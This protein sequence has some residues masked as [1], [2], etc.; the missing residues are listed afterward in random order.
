LKSKDKT[1]ILA[2]VL[3]FSIALSSTDFQ[4]INAQ[5]IKKTYAFVGATP[6]PIGVNQEVLIHLGITDPLTAAYGWEG[7]TVTIKRPDGV[8]ETL[9]PF[10]TDATGGTGTVYVPTMTGNYSLQVHFPEQASK[11]SARGIPSGTIYASSNSSLLTLVVT[12]EPRV[13]WPAIPLPT[14]YWSRPINS[15]LREWN[16]IAGSFLSYTTGP[17]V[18]PHSSIA[19]H[20]TG[21]ETGHILWTK[22]ITTGGLAGAEVR[23]KGFDAAGGGTGMWTPPII[24]AG[25]LYYN[26]YRSSGGTALEQEVV[27]VDIHTGEELWTKNLLDNRRIGFG[28]LLFFTAP[29]QHGVFA[30]IWIVNGTSWHAFDAYTG[31]WIYTMDNVPSG[32]NVYGPNGEILRYTV[33]LGTQAAQTTGWITLWNTTKVVGVTSAG[34]WNPYARSINATAGIEWN[35]TIPKGL[36]GAV[37]KIRDGVIIGSNYERGTIAPD[38][39]V[40][41]G[42]ST[43]PG[44][45]GQLLFNRTWDRPLEWVYMNIEDVS[46]DDDVFTVAVSETGQHYGFSTTT[47]ERIW[48]PTPGQHY[49]DRY[50]FASGNSWD[51]TYDGKLFSG[52]ISGILYCYDI[53]TGALLWKY[54]ASDKYTEI[55]WSDNWPFRIAFIADGKIYLE[56]TEHSP[57]DPLPRGAPFIAVDIE[58]GKEVFSLK[59]YGNQWGGTP[60]IADGIITMYSE[61]D[62]RIYALGRG[63][64]ATTVTAPDN[65]I[66]LGSSVMIRGTVNDISPGTDDLILQKRFPNGVPAISDQYMSEWMEYVHMQFPRPADLK[67]VPVTINVIDANN[68]HRNIGNTTTDSSGFFSLAWKPDIEGAYTVIATF[69]GSK[70]YYGS[71]ATTA[72]VVDPASQTPEPTQ[73]TELPPT[74]MYLMA[75]AAAIIIAIAIVGLVLLLA[76]RKRP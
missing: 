54:E 46:V 47:G 19:P 63:P 4:S 76:I 45:E 27:A 62:S 66:Q 25:V 57:I 17:S 1:I 56:H 65:G 8:T 10:T 13:Y 38:K 74:E 69:D 50:G 15:Q 31:R 6:N 40:H 72:F 36:P 7:V 5:T 58:T 59:L 32:A 67:G 22:Q 49:L 71:S 23:D 51:V 37:R 24:V 35:V 53:K 30:Y 16:I 52:S 60:A 2:V 33:N 14:E 12:E 55:L 29:N 3:I 75:G 41:W 28:Q 48:G 18:N 61:Y 68:N 73:V 26:R 43:S 44:R 34:T 11:F 39:L 70:S 20:T 21:P 64:S 9:G 42:I